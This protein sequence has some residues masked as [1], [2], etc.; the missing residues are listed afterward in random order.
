MS[1][2]MKLKLKK[3]TEKKFRYENLVI[4]SPRFFLSQTQIF[5]LIKSYRL[6]DSVIV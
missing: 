1:I 4:T 3:K 5:I 6:Q 2:E